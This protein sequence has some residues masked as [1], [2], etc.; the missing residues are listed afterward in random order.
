MKQIPSRLRHACNFA[1]V[2]CIRIRIQILKKIYAVALR[3]LRSDA[4][5]RRSLDHTLGPNNEFMAWLENSKRA[6][7]F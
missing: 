7:G 1:W 4:P 5:P 2:I 3:H 6:I